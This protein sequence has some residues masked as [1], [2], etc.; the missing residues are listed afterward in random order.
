MNMTINTGIICGLFQQRYTEAWEKDKTT[1]HIK[2]DTPE[3]ILAQQNCITM[4]KVSIILIALAVAFSL[5]SASS[6]V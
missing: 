5:S 2:P 1:L 4:S 6:G 3:I